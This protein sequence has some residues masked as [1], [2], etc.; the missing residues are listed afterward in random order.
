MWE[1]FLTGFLIVFSMVELTKNHGP[2]MAE[3]GM[4]NPKP[5]EPGERSRYTGYYMVHAASHLVPLVTALTRL[6]YEVEHHDARLGR[7]RQE[8]IDNAKKVLNE[9][10][11]IK[12]EGGK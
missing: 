7:L 1:L 10:Q 9:V 3:A 5:D 2:M 4:S 8:A 11:G 12:V 6:V